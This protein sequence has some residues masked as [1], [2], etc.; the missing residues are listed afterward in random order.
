MATAI[1][2]YDVAAAVGVSAR[3][4]SRY[5][6]HPDLLAEATRERIAAEIA[7]T[8]FRPSALANQLSHGRLEAVAV[9][10]SASGG[11]MDELHRLL[12]GHLAVDVASQGRDLL[13]IGVD[14]ANQERVIAEH[15][16]QRKL[17]GLLLLTAIHGELLHEIAAA[18][19]PTVSINW[20][21]RASLPG[22]RYVGIDYRASARDYVT[23]LLARRPSARL[24]HVTPAGEDERARGIAE[25]AATAGCPLGTVTA[26]GNADAT[27]LQV[28]EQA[29]PG[30]LVVGWSDRVALGLLAAAQRAGVAIPG[31]FALAGFDGL[32]AGNLVHPVLTTAVQPWQDMA[33]QAADLLVNDRPQGDILLPVEVRWGG[34]C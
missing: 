28:L 13:L 3:T 7:R 8:G 1:T 9:L 16:R 21:P 5:F 10:A 31:R 18:G 29:V 15:I 20:Q 32:D 25:G 34:T 27:L 22:N 33:R 30:T 11:L 14:A 24:I 17:G 4:V 19:M 23:A 12:L 26:T 2:I 6:N